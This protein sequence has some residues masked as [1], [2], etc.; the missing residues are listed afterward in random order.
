[1]IFETINSEIDLAK[2]INTGMFNFEE[3]ETNSKWLDPLRM[4]T[5][6]DTNYDI[7]S[8]QYKPN[9]PFN[10]ERLH[11][12]FE[13]NFMLQVIN[14]DDDDHDHSH[15]DHEDEEMKDEENEDMDSGSQED[16]TEEAY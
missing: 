5:Q 16:E 7:S 11:K 1:M 4:V 10:A 9:K 3:A 6:T 15:G 2:V 13:S 12:L 14:P 8:F